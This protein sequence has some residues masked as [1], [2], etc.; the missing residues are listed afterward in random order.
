MHYND[1]IRRDD[2]GESL[3]FA[4]A[5]DVLDPGVRMKGCAVC[6]YEVAVPLILRSS[7]YRDRPGGG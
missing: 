4:T 2:E 5:I 1:P 3:R 7:S 6:L